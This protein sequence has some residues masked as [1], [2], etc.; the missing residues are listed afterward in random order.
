[1]TWTASDSQGN[2]S[3][4]VQVVKVLPLVNLT[5][6]SLMAEG[7]VATISA[8]LSGDAADYP[9]EILYT[10]SGSAINNKDYQI[11]QSHGQITIDQGRQA[12]FSIEIMVDDEP[13]NDET[14]EITLDSA[15]KVSFGFSYSANSFNY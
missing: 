11:V 2:Q 6:S 14:I 4:A 3:K 8:V 9:V 5:P 15:T 1:V 7:G 12:S 13:E 10:V